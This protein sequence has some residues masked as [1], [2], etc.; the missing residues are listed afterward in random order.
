MKAAHYRKSRK[1]VLSS[2]SSTC[3]NKQ[4]NLDMCDM[5]QWYQIWWVKAAFLPPSLKFSL[6]IWYEH[7][8]TLVLCE[9]A[10]VHVSSG[11]WSIELISHAMKYEVPS[12]LL[13]LSLVAQFP[14]QA[15]QAA[16]LFYQ[17]RVQLNLLGSSMTL[18]DPRHRSEVNVLWH[19]LAFAVVQIASCLKW[20]PHLL[21]SPAAV[22]E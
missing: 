19:R 16:G 14:L 15:Q 10:K 7:E 12:C 1:S 21:T 11:F 20:I 5:E 4:R 9:W 2:K 3:S 13:P 8:L 22:L 18:H 6:R 17:L